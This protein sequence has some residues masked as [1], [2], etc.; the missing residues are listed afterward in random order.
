MSEFFKALEQAERDRVHQDHAPEPPPLPAPEVE[1]PAASST[2]SPVVERPA[3]VQKPTPPPVPPPLMPPPSP[4]TVFRP[5]L[6]VRQQRLSTFMRRVAG[7][8]P[9]LVAQVAPASVAAEAYRTVRANIELMSENGGLRRIIITSATGGDGKS[10]S[11]ANLAVVGAQAGRRICLIDADLRHPT[12]HEVFGLPNVDGL[13]AALEHGKPLETVA[14]STDIKNLSVVVAGRGNE[15]FHNLIT[16]Q[17]LERV[18]RESETAFD[19]VV[20]DTAP[21][22]VSDTLTVAALCDGVILV[23]RAGSMP[24]S[25]LQQSIAQIKQVKGRVLGVVLN[26]ADLRT[27]DA[28]AYRHYRAYYRNGSKD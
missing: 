4:A 5:S 12:L 8:S 23:V 1:A 3:V 18:L 21:V 17:R 24:F 19:L 26:Q 25:V 28:G 22:V 13:T 6:R 2:A 27:S 11:A 15:A 20:F 10:T 7:R 14:Q 16:A 9:V